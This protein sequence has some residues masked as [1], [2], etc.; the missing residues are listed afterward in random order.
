[1][2][3]RELLH[4]N[5]AEWHGR[6]AFARLAIGDDENADYHIAAAREYLAHVPGPARPLVT[7]DDVIA[8]CIER[9]DA[10]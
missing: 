1:M 2:T 6:E 4:L 10:A 7:A 3:G 5:T 8:A 9:R